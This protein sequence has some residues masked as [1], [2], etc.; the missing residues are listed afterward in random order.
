VEEVLSYGKLS[1]FE[2]QGLEKMLPDLIA[3]AKKGVEFV[4]KS[5]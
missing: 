3:Q 5:A 2:E 4:K 1:S